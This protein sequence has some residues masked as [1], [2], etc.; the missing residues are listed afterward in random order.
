MVPN[1]STMDEHGRVWICLDPDCPEL[2]ATELEAEDLVEAGVPAELARRLT[3]LILRRADEADAPARARERAQAD[4]ARL[5]QDLLE[6]QRLASEATAI[7]DRLAGSLH[8]SVASNDFT[9]GQQAKEDLAVVSAL[10]RS[11]ARSA[12]EAHASVAGIGRDLPG[13][14]AT[15]WL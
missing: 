8:V 9:E 12:G 11:G 1:V 7:A 10:S 4:L 3:K 2:A 5:Q 13:L 6:A 15:D 14:L